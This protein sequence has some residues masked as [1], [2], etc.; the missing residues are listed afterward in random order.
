MDV[1]HYRSPA[2]G[3]PVAKYLDRLSAKE[4]GR[5]TAS[6]VAIEE[7]DTLEGAAV[8]TRHIRE[9]LWELKVGEHR[10]FFVLITGPT[11]IL[12]HAY[13]KQGQKA[14]KQEIATALARMKEVLSHD[15]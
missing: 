12:L 3:D 7:A 8:D 15:P 6:L 10:V 5:L 1:R 9:R 2:G 4:A 14:P 11:L 13:K